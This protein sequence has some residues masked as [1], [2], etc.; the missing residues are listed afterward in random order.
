MDSG[1]D[2][3]SSSFSEMLSHNDCVSVGLDPFAPLEGVREMP[4]LPKR[5][6]L[7]RSGSRWMLSRFELEAEEPYCVKLGLIGPALGG[8]RRTESRAGDSFPRISPALFIL[9]SS[10]WSPKYLESSAVLDNCCADAGTL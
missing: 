9:R 7:T 8:F 2:V 4:K 6:G 1:E 5:F 3:G 10:R